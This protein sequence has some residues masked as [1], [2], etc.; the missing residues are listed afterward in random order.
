[1][2]FPFKKDELVELDDL[3]S[4]LEDIVAELRDFNNMHK[5]LVDNDISE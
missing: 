4:V 3:I 2:K 5:E 1:M